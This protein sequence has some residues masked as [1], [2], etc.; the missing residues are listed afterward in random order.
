MIKFQYD[1]E[2]DIPAQLKDN[3]KQ[4]GSVWILQVEGA[5]PKAQFEEFRDNNIKL[6]KERDDLKTKFADV[7]PEQYK[8][9]KTRAELLDEKKLVA[10]DGVEAAVE[11]RVKKMKEEYDAKLN[12]EIEKNTR[13]RGE[14]GKLKIDTALVQAGT[15]SGLRPEAVEDFVRRGQSVFSLDAEGQVVAL[16]NGEKRYNGAG[17]PLGI[18]DWVGEVAKDKGYSHLFNPSSGSGAQGGAGKAPTQ[19]PFQ[20]GTPHYNL[21]DQARLVKENPTLAATLREQAAA[22]VQ[23]AAT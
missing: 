18:D 23:N 5:V 11:A 19:N 7:D 12:T 14:I 21:M 2:A 15:K 4:V 17:A 6:L 9:L 22:I 10:A 13:A 8:T 20:K 1:N 3:Y 16:Q